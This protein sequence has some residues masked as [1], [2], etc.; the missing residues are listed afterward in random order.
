MQRR[1]VPCGHEDNHPVVGVSWEDAQA[2]C[3]WLGKK[4]GKTYRL[5][6]DQEWSI[7]VGLGGRENY[8]QNATPQSLN[9]KEQNYFPWGSAFPPETNDRP[10]NFGDGDCSWM[11]QSP[12][13]RQSD[14]LDYHDGWR[15]TSPVMNFKANQFGIYDM[16][17]NVSEWVQDWWNAEQTRRV[18][19]GSSFG[20]STRRQLVAS[21]RSHAEPGVRWDDFGFRVVLAKS[22]VGVNFLVPAPMRQGLDDQMNKD[23]LAVTGGPSAPATKVS[24]LTGIAALITS[25]D[26]DWSEP[27]NLGPGVNSSANEHNPT[28]SDD[29]LVIVF[30]SDRGNHGHG[31]FFEASRPRLDA[32]FGPAV[33]RT[34]ISGGLATGS[35]FLT[36]DGLTLFCAIWYGPGSLGVSDIYKASRR[37]RDMPWKASINLGEPVNS[38]DAEGFAALSPDGLKLLVTSNRNVGDKHDL[39]LIQR[40]S[41]AG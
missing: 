33:A 16:G 26:Y 14:L 11:D 36:G 15:T 2:F 20:C 31:E 13:T 4:E 24:P 29:G 37:Q 32:A 25:P 3:Q 18:V 39:W 17:G 9:S 27:E 21:V 19:R 35:P 28:L 1:G 41:F 10:G 30:N 5:P 34:D 8:D 6:T 7:A 12:S 40:K 23:S 38:A 22:D